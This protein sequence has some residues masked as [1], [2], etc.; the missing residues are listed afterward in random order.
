MSG[1]SSAGFPEFLRRWRWLL[2][3]LVASVLLREWVPAQLPGGEERELLGGGRWQLSPGMRADA[4]ETSPRWE[5]GAPVPAYASL[6]LADL[7]AG[8]EFLAISACA[9]D[10]VPARGVHLM[11]AS[12]RRGVLD[13][14]RQYELYGFPGL[15]RGECTAD[16]LPRREGDGA[17]V[18]QLLLE[19]SGQAVSLSRLTLTP[20]V[21]NPHWRLLR[22]A[23]LAL[24]L[25][26]L[27]P[28]FAAYARGSSRPWRSALGLA[29]VLSILFGCLVSVPLKA[30]IFA[31]VSGGR[32]VATT[33]TPASLLAVVFPF[34]GGFYIFTLGHAVLFAGAAFFL[35]QVSHRAWGDLL[36]LGVTTETLQIFV[37][38]RGPGLSDIAVDWGGILLAA[39]LLLLARLVQRIGLFPKH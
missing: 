36:M 11:L 22:R 31:L 17:A 39:L 7:P 14:N 9:A 4:T 24:G 16:A 28:V 38:G 27:V 34:R 12:Q 35:G 2:L 18:L 5:A 30:D 6:L 1:S 37:P 19:S 23:A 13:F 20:L 3:F 25:L 32:E 8:A 21:E 29:A 33:A 10:P 26:L 15:A